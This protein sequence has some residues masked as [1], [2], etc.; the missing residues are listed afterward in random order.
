MSEGPWSDAD[1]AVMTWHD[2]H[3]HALRVLEGVGGAG[4]LQLDL[5][6]IVDWLPQPGGGMQFRMCPVLL[7]FH[8]VTQLL[9]TLDYAAVAAAPGPFSLDAIERREAPRARAVA[10]VWNLRVNW[11]RGHIRFE[12]TGFTQRATG[13]VVVADRQHLRPDERGSG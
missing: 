8:R 2:N 9:V 11:P 10:Q 13:P 5:D 1:F 6:Y 12:A 7:V 4:E 3:V